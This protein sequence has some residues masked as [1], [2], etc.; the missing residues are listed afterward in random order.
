MINK[1]SLL[2]FL[3]IGAIYYA[4]DASVIKNTAE[5]YSGSNFGGTAKFNS[6]AGSMGALGGDLSAITVNPAGTGVFITGDVS[7]TL[8]VQGNKNNSNLFGNS[9]ESS[10]NN[11]NLGQAGGVVSFETQNNSPW[12]FVNLA[13]N[14]STKNIEDYVQTPGNSNIKDAVQYS[15]SN[16]NTVDD[17]LV[18]NGHA[19]DRTGTVSNL[20]VS[21]GGNYDNRIYLGAGLNF[22]SAELDQSDFFQ[23]QL[24]NLGEYAYYNKQYTPY[25]EAS[26]GFSASVGVIGKLNNNIRLGAAIESPT[27]WNLTRTY[28]EYGFNTNNSV[29]SEVF[30]ETRKLTTPMKLTLSGALVASKNFAVNVDYTL[31]LTKPKY[32]VQ[33]PAEDQLNDYFS[34]DYKNISDLRIGAEYRLGGFRL[35]GGYG[36]EGNPFD[37]GSLQSFN[38]AGTSGSNSYNSL[39]IGKRQTLAGG[40]GYD[41][42]SFYVDAGV[43]S[44][45]ATY[46]NPFFGG[47]YAVTIDNGFSVTDGDG[48]NNSTSIV[49]EV[50]NTR[51]N[52]FVTVGWKF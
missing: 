47:D 43:Q 9:F 25:R 10:Y 29:V 8:A 11:T 12:K 17:F 51:T 28:V 5:V 36:I 39:F 27:F 46:D 1:I 35:R 6:M 31:G 22:K 4:Q 16:G 50:K 33:G 49:S 3:S 18:Y 20:N 42:K 34:S 2:A 40:L 14:Y 37:T 15:D 45:T 30:D 41:F 23:L 26:N 52:F 24:Q 44:I 32:K 19:Y 48:I 38:S 7:A 21:L 13:F